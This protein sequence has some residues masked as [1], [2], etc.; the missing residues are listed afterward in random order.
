MNTSTPNT[1]SNAAAILAAG[2]AIG[3][4]KTNPAP[5]G[6]SYAVIPENHAL[7]YLE[8]A[9]AP[10]HPKAL[11]K[12]RDAASFIR[13]FGDHHVPTSRIFCTT[14]P[15]RFVAV[16]DEFLDATDAAGTIDGQATFR[17][18]R[19]EFTVPPSREWLLWN[20]ANRQHMSQLGFAEFL[21]D[22]LPDIAVPSGAELYEISLNF[23]A[24][25]SASF[26]SSQRLTDGSHNMQFRADN[27]GST[28]KLPEYITLQIPVFENEEARDLRARLRYR[29][30]D[31]TLTLWYELERPH[32]VLEAA[33]KAV[34]ERITE[35]TASVPLMGTPE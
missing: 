3:L 2:A 32:K 23:E 17:E 31:Q 34:F 5:H 29:A 35:K 26:V 30:K 7:E 28:V 4:P 33:F 11:V 27:S 21:Q 10:D 18:F 14:E 15:A 16:F 8:V 12:L 25:Q 24:Q 1:D 9:Y 19:A 6:K 20:A 22:N 13:Y